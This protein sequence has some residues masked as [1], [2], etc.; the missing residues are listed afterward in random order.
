MD[1]AVL[2][3]RFLLSQV[4]APKAQNSAR[5]GEQTNTSFAVALFAK[6]SVRDVL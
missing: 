5:E 6:G 4:S 2:L 3:L 1:D